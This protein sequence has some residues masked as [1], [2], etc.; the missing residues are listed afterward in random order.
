MVVLVLPKEI[1]YWKSL[2]TTILHITLIAEIL[3]NTYVIYAED[4][5]CNVSFF[6]FFYDALFFNPYLLCDRNSY[7]SFKFTVCYLLPYGC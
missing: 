3:H 7:N 6:T 1:M 4:R 5:I 2:G